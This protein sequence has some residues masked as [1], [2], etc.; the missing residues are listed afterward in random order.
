M[1]SHQLSF[2]TNYYY[3]FIKE[4]YIMFLLDVV[5]PS[6]GEIILY[7]LSVPE[8]QTALALIGVAAIVI[9]AIIIF[10]KKRR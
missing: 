1:Q 4:N 3:N 7:S 2:W 8:I 5:P 9:I 10:I 6:P